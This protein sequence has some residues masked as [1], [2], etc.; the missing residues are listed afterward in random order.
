ME[1]TTTRGRGRAFTRAA[2]SEASSAISRAPMTVPAGRTTSP[3]VTSWPCGRTFAPRRTKRS[4][5]TRALPRSVCSNGTTLSA[6]RG[7]GA[8]V[9]IL[10]AVPAEMANGRA[11]PAW[12]SPTTG[13]E[14]GSPGVAAATS[15]A[16][17]A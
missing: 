7:I 3:D 14:I 17:R 4:M 6:P 15:S 13:R 2:P 9:M 10:T 1:M 16:R 12:T 8:P 11:E 5:L